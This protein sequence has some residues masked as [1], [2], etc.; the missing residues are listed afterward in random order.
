MFPRALARAPTPDPGLAWLRSTEAAG[1]AKAA[2]AKAILDFKK[3]F[4]NADMSR[5]KVQVDF[6]E[7]RKATG[8][9]FLPESADSWADVLLIAR[10]DWT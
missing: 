7:K 1:L 4:P 6:D 3:R 8:E 5:F 2:K 9:V 10:K